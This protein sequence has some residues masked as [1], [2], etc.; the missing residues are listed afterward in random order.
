VTAAL[1]SFDEPIVLL[2]GGRDKKLPWEGMLA[3]AGQ[4]CRAIV[5]FGEAGELIA[6]AAQR[7]GVGTFTQ[8]ETVEEAV[9]AARQVA[10]PGDVVLL[11]PGATSY[12]AYP[13]FAARGDHFRALVN[14][15]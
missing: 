4:N 8:V 3:L 10:Q 13:D 11:S 5:A 14:A 12:D 2:L 9:A 15:L 7:A 6:A 1:R